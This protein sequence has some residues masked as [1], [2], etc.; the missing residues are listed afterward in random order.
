LFVIGYTN[1]SWTLKAD[2]VALYA[3]RLLNFLR[4]RGFAIAVPER[5][6]GVQEAPLLDFSSGYVRRAITE[7]PKQ[8]NRAPWL[9]HQN[10]L[11]DMPLL[12]FGRLQDGTLKFRHAQKKE[13]I[14]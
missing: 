7:L 6:A 13:K 10:Y 4:R 2:L 8:G 9:L 5:E 14:A 3:C 1:A 11:K 12:R